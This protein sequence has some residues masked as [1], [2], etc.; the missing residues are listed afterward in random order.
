MRSILFSKQPVL[1]DQKSAENCQ[2][3]CVLVRVRMIISLGNQSVAN[4]TLN[5]NQANY[6]PLV[7][8]TKGPSSWLSAESANSQHN[9]PSHKDAS[10]FYREIIST[11]LVFPGDWTDLSPPGDQVVVPVVPV[12]ADQ[13]QLLPLSDVVGPQQGITDKS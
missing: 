3:C 10:A 6:R 13:S 2:N 1:K 12:P 8:T 4:E 9:R 5:P 11:P 7:S